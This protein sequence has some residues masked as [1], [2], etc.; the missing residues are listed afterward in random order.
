M[1]INAELAGSMNDL[2][3]I[4]I[5]HLKDEIEKRK[6]A[7]NQI[8]RIIAKERELNDLQTKFLSLSPTNLKT[9]WRHIISSSLISNTQTDQQEKESHIKPLWAS[10]QH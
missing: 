10:V 3:L 1:D 6:E 7:R 9:P 8:N 4:C 2:S 5:L